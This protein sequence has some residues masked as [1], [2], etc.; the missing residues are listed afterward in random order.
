MGRPASALAIGRSASHVAHIENGRTAPHKAELIVLAQLYSVDT[1]MLAALEDLRAEASK[2][3][4]WSTYGLPEGMAGYVGLE[5]D[6]TAMRCMELET[7]PGL[8]QTE[9]YMRRLYVLDGRLRP[10]EIDKRVRARVRR[11]GRLAAAGDNPLQLSAVVSQG[12]LERCVREQA[13]LATEQLA[14]LLE[15]AGQ[16]NVDL[17]VLPFDHGL[18]AAQAG[19]FTLLSFPKGLLDDAAYHEYAVGG[20]IIDDQSVVFELNTKFSELH[21]QALDANESS[22]MIATLAEQL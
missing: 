17:R 16:P 21:G 9:Q 6:A 3:G 5:T 2:R 8:L 7:I 18:H 19:P 14:R 1:E 4:W 12:A 15:R 13:T 22:A 10:L 11:Q 20:H